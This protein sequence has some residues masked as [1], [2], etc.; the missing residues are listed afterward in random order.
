MS[1]TF[2]SP[3]QPDGQLPGEGG[4]PAVP[5]DA[6][7]PTSPFGPPSPLPPEPLPPDPGTQPPPFEPPL[8][9]TEPPLPP[10]PEPFP[11]PPGPDTFP[12]PGDPD[13]GHRNRNR[14][15]RAEG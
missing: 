14:T 8:P 13:A 4:L 6:G 15:G 2:P 10:E 9:P 3:V 7:D 5:P 1:S 12:V 11:A